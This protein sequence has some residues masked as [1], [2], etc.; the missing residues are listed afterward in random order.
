MSHPITDLTQIGRMIDISA[1]R[2]DSMTDEVERM[3]SIVK[4]FHCICASPMPYCTP[5]VVEQLKDTPDTVVTGVVSFPSGAETTATKVLMAKDLIG[6]GCRE[7]DMVINVA[8]LK[9][10][11]FDY[12]RDDIKA[13]VTAAEEIPVKAIIEICYLADDEI[14]RASQLAVEAGA[15]F[16]KTGT[17]W[18]TKPSTVET[19]KLIR[20]TVG[21]SAKIK[22]AGGVHDLDILLDLM[23]A[24]CDR[25]GVGVRTAGKIFEEAYRRMGLLLPD[26][27]LRQK[28]LSV[29]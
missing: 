24:G 5:Y 17:G 1:V 19:V 25:F 20:R 18:G 23:D 21:N 3:I 2:T 6:M 12:V 9:S 28:Q 4:A 8:A 11:A 22:C 10:G 15:A 14:V 29:G 7:L 27:S 16:I 13:V 26:L